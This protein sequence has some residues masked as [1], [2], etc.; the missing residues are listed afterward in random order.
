MAYISALQMYVYKQF[1]FVQH[2]LI[3]FVDIYVYISVTLCGLGLA[4]LYSIHYFMGKKK[5][6][7]KV[8][9]LNPWIL[10]KSMLYDVVTSLD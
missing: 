2:K 10:K 5:K 1:I 6:S 8:K 9:L 3:Q 7:T 4:Y